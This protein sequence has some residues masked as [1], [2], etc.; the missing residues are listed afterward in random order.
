MYVV[1]V[2]ECEWRHGSPPAAV[3]VG[4]ELEVEVGAVEVAEG[5]GLH[6]RHRELPQLH[7]E[8]DARE[9]DLEFES[10]VVRSVQ[11]NPQNSDSLGDCSYTCDVIVECSHV[12]CQ[13]EQQ[14]SRNSYGCYCNA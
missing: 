3:H 8:G 7:Q 2:P 6:L 11:H 13:V 12:A 1:L 4:V 9:P 5:L 14:K 10:V